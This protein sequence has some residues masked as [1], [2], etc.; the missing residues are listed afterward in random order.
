MTFNKPITIYVVA[1]LPGWTNEGAV[2]TYKTQNYLLP[3][4]QQAATSKRVVHQH[5]Q[6]TC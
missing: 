6:S 5:T 3:S 2:S 4:K 1:I